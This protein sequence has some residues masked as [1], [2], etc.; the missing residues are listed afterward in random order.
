MTG[1]TARAS[2]INYRLTQ[3]AQKAGIA[4]GLGS[5]RVL[6]T[7]PYTITTFAVRHIAPDIPLL[8]VQLNY[9]VTPKEYQLFS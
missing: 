5:I 9:G 7:K 2:D 8:A 3:A 6:L 1:G 4:M